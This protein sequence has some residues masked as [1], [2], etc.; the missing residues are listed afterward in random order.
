MI[1]SVSCRPYELQYNYKHSIHV[2]S[3]GI[4]RVTLD[5]DPLLLRLYLL[6]VIYEI[7]MTWTGADAGRFI[8]PGYVLTMPVLGRGCALPLHLV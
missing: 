2:R 8:R 5:L 7:E 6:L 1:I 3:I 4:P